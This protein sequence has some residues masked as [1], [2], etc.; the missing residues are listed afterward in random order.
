MKAYRI[1]TIDSKYEEDVT[2]GLTKEVAEELFI[3]KI[4]EV[5]ERLKKN[6]V[7][8]EEFE[9]QINEAKA[10]ISKK[11]F[12]KVVKKINY[13]YVILQTEEGLIGKIV[14]DV[15]DWFNLGEYSFVKVTLEEI[16]ILEKAGEE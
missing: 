9:E 14:I 6:W 16:E 15:K 5:A 13:P 3:Q 1:K 8:E 10:E 4:E 11:D 2:Y 7:S 12:T